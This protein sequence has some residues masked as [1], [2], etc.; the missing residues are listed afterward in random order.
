[1]TKEVS[2]GH[3]TKKIQ[4]EDTDRRHV[5]LKLR[6]HFDGLTQG[7]FFRAMLTGYIQRHPDVVKYVE[8]VKNHR[9]K[10][11]LKE[12]KKVAQTYAAHEDTKNKYSLDEEEIE[13]IFDIIREEYNSI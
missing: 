6:L 13:S 5:E 2:M 4:F 12:K 8:V 9:K 1:M 10:Y 11:S 7:D 3:M